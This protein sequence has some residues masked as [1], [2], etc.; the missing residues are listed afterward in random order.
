MSNETLSGTAAWFA[1]TNPTLDAGVIGYESDTGF[2]KTGD[3]VTP[4]VSLPYGDGHEAA[5]TGAKAGNAALTSLI[6]VLA[7]KG[8]ITDQ[9]T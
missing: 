6:A 8:I 9:T 3:G 4:W 2:M 5:V 1:G 7:Q